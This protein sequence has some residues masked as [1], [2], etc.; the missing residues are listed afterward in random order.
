MDVY[1]YQQWN[2][3]AWENNIIEHYWYELYNAPSGLHET[4]PALRFS[5]YPN[6]ANTLLN[7]D[8]NTAS[9]TDAVLSISNLAG[10]ELLQITRSSDIGDNYLTTDVSALSSGLY[11][12]SITQNGKS[13][14]VKFVKQ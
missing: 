13:S 1:L 11:F 5:A 14:R 7:I 6:P 9:N 3:G 8:Y 12:V 2:A 10:Q 4:Q